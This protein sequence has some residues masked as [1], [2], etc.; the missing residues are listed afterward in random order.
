[1][2]QKP[3]T[4]NLNESLWKKKGEGNGISLFYEVRVE[5]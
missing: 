1:M 2:T 4:F 3:H 5:A